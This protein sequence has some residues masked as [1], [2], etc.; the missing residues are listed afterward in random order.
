MS[1]SAVAVLEWTVAVSDGVTTAGA[2]RFVRRVLDG[3]RKVAQGEYD[4]LQGE[5]TVAQAQ[6]SRPRQSTRN[7][8]G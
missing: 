1:D 5:Q 4:A 2:A 7:V 8:I 3:E 6:P